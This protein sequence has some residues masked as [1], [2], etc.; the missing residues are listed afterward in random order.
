MR[1]ACCCLARDRPP[2]QTT[3]G[4]EQGKMS[5]VVD[6][7][8]AMLEVSRETWLLLLDAGGGIGCSEAPVG[9]PVGLGVGQLPWVQEQEYANRM[10]AAIA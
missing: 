3:W 8:E 1:C 2:R 9:I 6:G 7:L 5:Y 10:G 4:V